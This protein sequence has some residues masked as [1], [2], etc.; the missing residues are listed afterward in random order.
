MEREPLQRSRAEELF[1]TFLVDHGGASSDA[2][3]ALCAAHRDCAGELELLR[4]Q[5]V[6]FHS[7]DREL[8]D[9]PLQQAAP[10]AVVPH[11]AL[12]VGPFELVSQLGRGGMG[13]VWEANDIE[14]K[15]RVALKLLGHGAA[16]SVETLARFRREAE[17]TGRLRDAGIVAVHRAGEADGR[18]YIA[19][20]LVEGGRSLRDWL[21]ERARRPELPAEHFREAALCVERVARAVA[22][23]HAA[24]I[25]HRDLKP[26]NILL[27]A[28]G[29]PKVADFGLA[30]IE[31]EASLSR[32]GS[33]VGTWLY[34]SPEQVEGKA[35]SVDARSD[36]FALGVTL[37][38]CLTM[39]RPF[40]GDTE[41]QVRR[42]ILDLEP[43]DPRVVR[44]KCPRDLALI[45]LRALEKRPERRYAS[46]SELADDLRRH[47]EHQ[48]V[49]AREPRALDRATKWIRRHPT[50]STALSLASI[51]LLAISILYVQAVRARRAADEANDSL[52]RA[53]RELIGAENAA[54]SAAS[55]AERDAA[56]ARAESDSRRR[57]VDFITG[58]F[59]SADPSLSGD[60]VPSVRELV[61]RGLADVRADSTLEAPIRA[62][63]LRTLA[64]LVGTLGDFQE[65]AR[66][67]D[68]ARAVHA[69]IGDLDSDE[70]WQAQH[71]RGVVAYQ[72]GDYAFAEELLV[73]VAQRASESMGCE[74][75]FGPAELQSLAKVYLAQGRYA[76]AQALLES[77]L[78]VARAT[79]GRDANATLGI[80]IDLITIDYFRADWKRA[81]E[82]VVPLLATSARAL[83]L[84]EP[85]ALGVHNLH[86]LILHELGRFDEAERV[87][88][89]LLPRCARTYDWE[90]PDFS[91]LRQ[92]LARE[93]QSTGRLDL[94]EALYREELD[95]CDRRAGPRSHARQVIAH[96]LATCLLDERRFADAHEV[97]R[98]LF[99]MRRESLG[100]D[101]PDTLLTQ[102]VVAKA[103]HLD[104]REAEA[105]ATAEDLL[106]RTPSDD[107]ERPYRRKLADEI[108]AALARD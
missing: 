69:R 93:W 7:T 96:N 45:A 94:A 99:E 41:A 40:E 22:L 90:H 57:V 12:R 28:E 70:F 46:M 77:A 20:E 103:L 24:G 106:S 2:F 51:S 10:H 75:A 31:G 91:T 64:T 53:N 37:Y 44:S 62:R 61:E 38:E 9:G 92:N 66:A 98:E 78:A 87:Y 73:P 29:A 104:G 63:L 15:R 74:S 56:A 21:D 34:A 65:S 8:V 4:A 16:L 43:L 50:V 107:Y 32:S 35:A 19:Y 42:A 82:R 88:G 39:R 84:G 27:T 48:P 30:K 100:P 97:A 59:Q 55:D 58:L 68:E 54:R 71:D 6:R 13:E 14:L 86:A 72:L 76:E 67:L 108:R 79:L 49:L 89:E 83:E 101:A 11:A 18:F 26:Q 80:E 102:Y 33:F 60:R 25:V 81:L 17:A 1:A 105:L 52:E 95:L 3:T 5:W 85:N 36:V 23:A 47:L